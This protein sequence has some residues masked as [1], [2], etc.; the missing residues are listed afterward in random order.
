MSYALL[1]A[2]ESAVNSQV[3]FLPKKI[4]SQLSLSS[5]NEQRYSNNVNQDAVALLASTRMY[6]STSNNDGKF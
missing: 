5:Q 4:N 1:E 2:V 3:P 6:R